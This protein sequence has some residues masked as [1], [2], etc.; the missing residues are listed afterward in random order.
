[1]PA[2]LS[3]LASS[4]SR[5]VVIVLIRR[6]DGS[7]SCGA[8]SEISA[9]QDPL[10][11]RRHGY[12]QHKAGG[13]QAH[14]KAMNAVG[15]LPARPTGTALLT[16]AGPFRR[17]GRSRGSIRASGAQNQPQAWWHKRHWGQQGHSRGAVHFQRRP[18]RS[19]QNSTPCA[20]SSWWRPSGA[21][22]PRWRSPAAASVC[23]SSESG[24]PLWP[25]KGV[26]VA[27]SRRMEGWAALPRPGS[28]NGRRA[29]CTAP[30][31]HDP[32][33]IT[34]W[35]PPSRA[36][37]GPWQRGATAGR[38]CSCEWAL[39]RSSGWDITQRTDQSHRRTRSGRSGSGQAAPPARRCAFGTCTQ[40]RLPP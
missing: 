26:D 40:L 13:C 6:G 5:K 17:R 34:P 28:A 4:H 36:G 10:D 18:P 21:S 2:A 29:P 22:S 3:S 30:Q 11:A 15:G 23:S 25:S 16:A 1:M 14:P 32:G 12:Q 37:S 20:R 19:V 24:A 27:V 35:Q 38:R 8:G 7:A 31:A 33:C 9:W 39:G